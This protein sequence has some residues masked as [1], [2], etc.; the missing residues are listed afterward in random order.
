MSVLSESRTAVM[1]EKG[2]VPTEGMGKTL[3]RHAAPPGRPTEPLA[4]ED[5]EVALG[6]EDVDNSLVV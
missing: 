1:R 3:S 6:G 4:V 2:A 5:F